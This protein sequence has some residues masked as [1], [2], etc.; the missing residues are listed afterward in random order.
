MN[1]WDSAITN[2][3]FTGNCSFA[4]K[5]GPIPDPYFLL[6]RAKG[7]EGEIAFLELELKL[8]ADLGLVGF[9]NAGKSSLLA[10]MSRAMPE[11]APYPFTT[12]HPLVG[13][14]EYRDGFSV[15]AAD[16]PGLIGG[17]SQGRGRGHD[18][19]RHLERTK[20]LLYI[21]DAAGVD[22]RDPIEDLLTL[23]DELSAYGDGDMLTRPALVVANKLDL[24]GAEECKAILFELGAAAKDAG[25]RF[26]GDVIG[27]SAGVTGVGLEQLS[28]AIRNV[29]IE[30]ENERSFEGKFAESLY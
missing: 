23:T 9:P 5:H 8:I 27:I 26:A 28:G 21:V 2:D 10:A 12:L 14:I 3:S 29:V 1:E 19:L 30:S 24:L 4:K 7:K 13:C 11:I 6:N 17:A 16:V 18:F 15:V 22:G 20:A 25:I